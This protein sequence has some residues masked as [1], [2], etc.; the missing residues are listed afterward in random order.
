M[1]E[2]FDFF[3]YIWRSVIHVLSLATFDFYG[4]RVNLMAILFVLMVVGFVI[5]AFWRGSKA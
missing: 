5:T 4:Y 2:F 1:A 3:V